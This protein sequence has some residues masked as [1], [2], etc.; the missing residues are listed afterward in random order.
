MIKDY[1]SLYPEHTPYTRLDYADFN[2]SKIT[3]VEFW[4]LNLT[5]DG[6]VNLI[7]SAKIN[8]IFYQ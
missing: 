6:F 3:K 5:S 8:E 1:Q 4:D 7:S 2:G